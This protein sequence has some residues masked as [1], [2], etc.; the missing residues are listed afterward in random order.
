VLP[1]DGLSLALSAAKSDPRRLCDITPHIR[2][3]RVALDIKQTLL[4][5]T[6]FS[7]QTVSH[8][9]YMKSSL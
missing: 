4:P 5:Y 2:V 3:P 1:T 6:A 9:G 8:S 7:I